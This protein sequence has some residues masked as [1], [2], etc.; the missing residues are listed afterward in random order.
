MASVPYVSDMKT[1][2]EYI[3]V[4]GDPTKQIA[5]S[6]SDAK[7]A[8][9]ELGPDLVKYILRSG[10]PNAHTSLGNILGR[11]DNELNGPIT[12][13]GD[14]TTNLPEYV[15]T[16][17]DGQSIGLDTQ[18]ENKYSLRA[19]FT[20]D[21]KIIAKAVEHSGTIDANGN[22]EFKTVLES[23]SL[24]IG[25][26]TNNGSDT[27]ISAD[28][29]FTMTAQFSSVVVGNVNLYVKSTEAITNKAAGTYSVGPV[30]FTDEAFELGS[31]SH[32]FQHSNGDAYYWNTTFTNST[33]DQTINV[34]QSTTDGSGDIRFRVNGA[35][36]GTCNYKGEN[37]TELSSS[38]Y[39]NISVTWKD[40]GTHQEIESVT[41]TYTEPGGG[42]AQT[43]VPDEIAY[44][45]TSTSV[46]QE[47]FLY[48][49]WTATA[50]SLTIQPV[51]KVSVQET[52]TGSDGLDRIIVSGGST[53]IYSNVSNVVTWQ[54]AGVN[55]DA[56]LLWDEPKGAWTLNKDGGA[57]KL[58]YGNIFP[59]ASDLPSAS[60]YHGMFA[61]VHDT[62]R[63]YFAHS[64]AWQEILDLAGNQT[65]A[66]NLEFAAGNAL[67]VADSSGIKINNIDL[68]NYASFESAL[69]TAK[70]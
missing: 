29:G 1:K 32:N 5:F 56:E 30:S 12:K 41:V 23:T 53:A 54:T 20:P 27:I 63:G 13:V 60:T 6:E 11:S 19:Y 51:D 7:T 57:A 67:K 4:Y 33:Y 70:S 68:G 66:G 35:N 61:H 52:D 14:Q 37:Y 42:T 3:D 28:S 69:T 49:L 48:K 34:L 26:W 39:S 38:G 21:N 44:E 43:F 22:S 8:G 24:Q 31:T 25:T 50:L 46:V 64:G 59:T 40:M 17:G 47:A 9:A 45:T 55:G 18:L 36:V 15:H 62:G 16:N 58:Y 2:V 65:L 10:N